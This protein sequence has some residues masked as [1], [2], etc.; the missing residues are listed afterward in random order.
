MGNNASNT[1]RGLGVGGGSKRKRLGAEL[2]HRGADLGVVEAELRREG[3]DGVDAWLAAPAGELG[4]ERPAHTDQ[5]GGVAVGHL[6]ESVPDGHAAIVAYRYHGVKADIAT[7]Y[8]RADAEGCCYKLRMGVGQRIREIRERRGLTQAQVA[9]ALS[10]HRERGAPTTKPSTISQYESGARDPSLPMLE[11]I[12]AALDVSPSVFW[13]AS[14]DPTVPDPEPPDEPVAT[15]RPGGVYASYPV[16]SFVDASGDVTGVLATDVLVIPGDKQSRLRL[17]HNARS[18]RAAKTEH[19]SIPKIPPGAELVKA[20][21][22]LELRDTEEVIAPSYLL[23]VD[24]KAPPEADKLVVAK[25]DMIDPKAAA[26]GPDDPK[27][28]AAVRICRYEPTKR[29]WSLAAIDG[30]G[31]TFGSGDGWSIVAAVLWWRP[32]P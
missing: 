12:A 24:R 31:M 14:P 4:D 20:I 13:D 10:A 23:V 5:L 11:K 6:R 8:S 21:A 16:E 1:S 18:N 22:R 3:S 25:K 26:D 32:A 9:E 2:A 27:K 7:R 29:G 17:R 15:G 19:V 28:A 30:S